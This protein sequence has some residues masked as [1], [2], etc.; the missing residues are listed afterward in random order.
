VH[1][2]AQPSIPPRVDYSLTPMGRQT[3]GKLVDL[4]EF[5]ESQMPEVTAAQA[6]HDQAKVRV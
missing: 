6:R 4:I 3:A 2:E 5:V 1:R